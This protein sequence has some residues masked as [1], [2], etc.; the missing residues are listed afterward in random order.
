MPEPN[1][2][3]QA[4]ASDRFIITCEL[5]P[6]QGADPSL[7]D[8]KISLLKGKIQ[9]AVVP[10]NHQ[11]KL[12]MSPL[13]FSRHL[14][15]QGVEPIMT[16]ACRDRNRLAL[17]SDL[18]G[19]ASLGISNILALTGDYLSWGD[20][21]QAKP[22][23]DLDSIQLLQ[24]ISQLKA[25]TNLVGNPLKGRLPPFTT[26]ALVPLKTNPLGPQILKFRKKIAAGADF[27]LSHP[28]FDLDGIG[29]FLS[30]ISETG[31]PLL[32]TI[33]LFKP[34]DFTGPQKG[35]LPGLVIPPP[36]LERF[37]T[38][39]EEELL[40]RSLEM[41]AGIIQAVKKDG[42]FRGIHLL[43]RGAEERLGELL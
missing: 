5:D 23:F 7:K 42:R 32:A 6:P 13:A 33:R 28:L 20:H 24:S 3:S 38:L 41:A 2:F 11:A 37:S 31:K 35:R 16:L 26:G 40:S 29:E 1:S 36:F 15:D 25:G 14:L 19:A 10:D 18:L 30:I 8:D 17:Q 22:V 4:L 39:P 9:A 43:L 12:H 27:F 21:P 34:K